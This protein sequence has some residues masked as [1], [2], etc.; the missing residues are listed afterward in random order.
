M[1]IEI[2]LQQIY[3]KNASEI[4]FEQLYRYSYKIVSNKQAELLLERV[5]GFETALLADTVVPMLLV[6]IT[7]DIKSLVVKDTEKNNS[8]STGTTN[9]RRL[10]GE[11]FLQGFKTIWDDYSLCTNMTTDVLLYMDRSLSARNDP[12]YN[13]C[14]GLFKNALT[15]TGID[16]GDTNITPM[17]VL[18]AVL[19]DMIHMERQGDVIDKSLV[20]HCVNLLQELYDTPKQSEL[21][22]IYLTI[23]EPLLLKESRLF[24]RDE[25]K[26]LL[27][28]GNAS[29]WLSQ[30]HKRMNEEKERCKTILPG[31]L[32]ESKLLNVVYD[33]MIKPYLQEFLAM[34]TTGFKSMIEN[35]RFD[36]LQ[37]LYILVEIVDNKKQ[38][39]QNALRKMVFDM[40]SAMNRAI[41]NPDTPA[42]T[43]ESDDTSKPA[44]SNSIQTDAAVRWVTAVLDLRSKF[45]TILARSFNDDLILQSG[46]TKSF[47]EFIN[48]FE[49]SSEFLSL[50]V[51][52]NM[53]N[54]QLSDRTEEETDSVL[55]KA[56]KILTYIQDKDLFERYY[57]KHLARRLLQ[58][59]SDNN[60]VEKLM[61]SKMKGVIGNY[62]TAKLEGM[63]KD[64]ARST[65]LTNQYKDHI[66][67]L[68][69]QDKKQIDLAINVLTTNNWPI[70]VMGIP[71]QIKDRDSQYKPV[72]WPAEMKQLQDS[73]RNYYNTKHT[74]RQLT[75]V[76]YLGSA[77][78]RCHFPKIDGKEGGI[79]GKERMHELIVSTASLVVL[80]QFNDLEPGESLSFEDLQSRTNL[81]SKE[82]VRLLTALAVIPKAKV[83]NKEP[84]NKHVK[85]GDRFSFNERF[86]S[87]SFKIKAPVV[88]GINKAEGADERKKTVDKNDEDRGLVVD[89]IIV[90]TMK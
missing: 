34:E 79:L 66:V 85:P 76:P 21:E 45:D 13:I 38:I 2:A 70:E 33:E 72:I 87:K 49:R 68:G 89:A 86:T 43:A 18:N 31:A 25:C 22:K 64:M 28:A 74:G 65:E 57:K 39:L 9:E 44:S 14:M 67:A 4:S 1:Q 71:S 12:I 53:K 27:E 69:A 56:I 90:R 35:D 46:I 77:D 37:M 20:A 10:N 82:L 80:L 84:A 6:L 11:K 48:E 26:N 55:T 15:E 59:K 58:A 51:D 75:W 16:A 24:Y 60:D 30:T 32:T 62:F 73:F 42:K 29:T 54:G 17:Q 40:G 83:L 23:F 61:I 41:L 5:E 7:S 63:F 52:S 3:T 81:E 78:V 47:Q 88:S 8:K 36:D 50:F 19:L